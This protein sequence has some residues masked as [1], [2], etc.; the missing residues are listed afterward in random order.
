MLVCIDPGHAKNTAGKQSPDGSLKEYEFNRYV[1]RRLKYYLEQHGVKTMFSCDLDMPRD[2]SLS[3]RCNAANNA[4]ADLFISIHA[5]AY[6]LVGWN[7]ANGWEIFYAAGSSCGKEL[8]RAIHEASIPFLQLRDRGVKTGAYTVLINTKMPAVLIEHGFYTNR[9]ECAKLKD[10]AFREQCAIADAKGILSYLGVKWLGSAEEKTEEQAQKKA[11]YAYRKEGTTHIIECDPLKLG[12][13]IADKKGTS[14]DIA[15]FVNGGYFMLQANGTTFPLHHLVDCGNILSNYATHGKPVTTLCV[16]YDGVVQMKKVLDISKE[17]GL[18]FAISGASLDDYKADG[19][20]GKFLD[21]IRS[22]N[23]TYIGYRKRDNKIVIC[24]RP[25]TS[26]ARAKKTFENLGV[27]M[28]MT[29]DG[30]GSTCMRVGGAWKIKTTRQIN[31]IV[32]W[33]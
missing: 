31:S 15:N 11:P 6:G 29:L 25:A 3:A 4:K 33:E 16:F 13:Y 21:I 27:D 8:A 22:A 9:E 20:V 32:M 7:S 10:L 24:V 18:K 26:I 17:K 14:I 30:G 2:V 23:R 5:N 1:A 19:F 28:G 12:A